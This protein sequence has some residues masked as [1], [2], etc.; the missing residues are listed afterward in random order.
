MR[1]L[2]LN[3]SFIPIRIINKYEAICKVFLGN[4]T[5]IT[6]EDGNYVELSFPFWSQ[7]TIWPDDQEFV[8]S[9]TMKIAVP[10][11]IRYL[12]YDKIPKS[13][14]KLTR[15][16]IYNRDHHIC[17]L[18]GKEFNDRH[19]SI[20]HIIPVSRGGKNTWENMITC[21]V[22]CNRN[23][24]D[25]LLSELGIKPKFLAKRPVT[26]NIQR[27]KLEFGRD[28]EEWKFFGV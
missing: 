25:Q 19:L 20:D 16:S 21:C 24:G 12:H 10:R 13:T 5:A 8:H 17:Y 1:T 22:E 18:C 28:F 26:S 6:F 2:C 23:K 15:K 11:T 14:L 7:R 4:A 9:A 3:K 27:L